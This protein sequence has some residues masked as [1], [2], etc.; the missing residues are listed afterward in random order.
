MDFAFLGLNGF[1]AAGL[2]MLNMLNMGMGLSGVNLGISNVMGTKVYEQNGPVYNGP[3]SRVENQPFM[4]IKPDIQQREAIDRAKKFAIEQSVKSAWEKQARQQ[5]QLQVQHQQQQQQQLLQAPAIN[6]KQQT[7]A[8]LSRIYVGSISYDL[9]EDAIR[10]AFVPFGPIRSVSLSWDQMTQKHKGFA[11]IEYENPESAQLAVEQMNDSSLGGRQLKVGRPS[12]LPR[13]EPMVEEL[14][15]EHNLEKRIYVSGVHAD[16][17][18][19]DLGLVFEAFGK[20]ISCKLAPDPTKAQKHRGFGYIEYETEQAANDAVASMNLFDLGGQLLRVGKAMSP[21]EGAISTSN[22]SNVP[23]A[24]AV[25]AASATAKVMAL[26]NNIKARSE[27]LMAGNLMASL[28]IP[29]ISSNDTSSWDQVEAQEVLNSNNELASTS[30]D[31]DG[32]TLEHQEN[33]MIRGRDARSA[34]MQKLIRPPTQGVLI[35]R[36]MVGPEDCDDD[37]EGEVKEECCKYGQVDRV[38]IYQELDENGSLII[39]IFV[40]FSE[41]ESVDRAVS[42]LHGRYFA[43]RQVSAE[44]YDLDKF[45]ANDLTG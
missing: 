33:F 9:K 22:M 16:L 4:L 44:S 28:G 41:S 7:L 31:D 18:D 17:S 2:P 32:G 5:Q 24:A 20:I 19:E 13:A 43:G 36:N 38:V 1:A 37:L 3:G 27:G 35:L 6:K 21:P 15:R 45:D 29:G 40:V 10:Q 23:V 26:G 14:V 42:S 12:N 34:I 8:L 11:F 25:A 39:K 30:F